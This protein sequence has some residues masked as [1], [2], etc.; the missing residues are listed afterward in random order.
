MALEAT[1][2]KVD[3]KRKRNCFHVMNYGRIPYD[4]HYILGVNGFMLDE[5]NPARYQVTPSLG[6]SNP[7][8]SVFIHRSVPN[9]FIEM[10][11]YHELVEA[12]LSLVDGIPRHEAHKKAI[13]LESQYVKRYYG[14]EKLERL[15]KWRVATLEG[16]S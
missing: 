11:F 3:M 7:G 12:E 6:G 4:V 16:Y 9:E 5:R 13:E 1:I 14:D 8:L 2:E 15:K 10:V